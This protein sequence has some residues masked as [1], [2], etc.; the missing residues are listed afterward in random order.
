MLGNPPPLSPYIYEARDYQD[1]VIR[2][3]FPYD[4][5]TKALSNATVF[6]DAAC[7]YTTIIVGV[8]G[9]GTVETSTKTFSVPSGTHTVTANAM[10]SKGINTITDVLS[11]QIT[12]K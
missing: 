8:G 10:S 6:R 12:A 2:I 11:L 1:N 7:I 4:N 9:D 3:T 5:V